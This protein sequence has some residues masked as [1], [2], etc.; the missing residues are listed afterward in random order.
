VNIIFN[1]FLNIFLW[2]VHASFPTSL[3]NSH[4]TKNNM[5]ITS[6]IKTKCNIKRYL[7]QIKWNS[8]DPS[9]RKLYKLYCTSLARSILK[10]TCCYYDQQIIDSNGRI[11]STWNIVKTLSGNNS[12]IDILPTSNSIS[13]TNATPCTNPTNIAESFNEYILSLANTINSNR[14][15]N[16]NTCNSTDDV[17]TYD[18]YLSA[19]QIRTFPTV[20]YS[21]VS[22]NEIVNVINKIKIANSYG[23]DEISVNI[24]KNCIHYIV[25]LF[26]YI[27]DRSLITGI[28]PDHLKFA[29]V[30]PINKK[31]DRNNINNYR[32]ISLLTSFSTIFEVIYNRL[33]KHPVNN[34]ILVK[35]QFG[36]RANLSTNNAA[37]TLYDQI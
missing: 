27:V 11:K 18:D 28:F 3:A 25:S 10:T 36:F 2:Y 22:A 9:I 6:N 15:S 5:W 21:L 14:L 23:Y 8:N 37:Y 13:S 33:Y 29:V 16:S 30:K 26:T 20:T 31:G 35:E 1:S 24:L 4:I 12:Y 19:T 7:Y 17:K 34:N 32:P